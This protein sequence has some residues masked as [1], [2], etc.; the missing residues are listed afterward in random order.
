MRKNALSARAGDEYLEYGGVDV[1]TPDAHANGNVLQF[2]H[3]YAYGNHDAYH[4]VCVG[5]RVQSLHVGVGA[6]GPPRELG[7]YLRA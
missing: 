4:H 2:R 5:A 1:P 6:G 3:C 7:R